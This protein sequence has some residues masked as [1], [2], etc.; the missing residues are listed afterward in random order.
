MQAHIVALIVCVPLFI[1][2]LF[3]IF[4]GK[5]TWQRP[6]RGTAPGEGQT[7]KIINM[8]SHG[9]GRNQQIIMRHTKDL[10]KHAQAMMPEKA[11]KKD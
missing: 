4:L 1:G 5:S 7:V 3:M 11:R 2:G 6:Q 9:R 10:N 8:H